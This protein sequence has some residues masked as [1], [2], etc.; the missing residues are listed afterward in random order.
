MVAAVALTAQTPSGESVLKLTA[1]TANVSGAGETVKFNLLHWSTDAERDQFRMRQ[2]RS[3]HPET[4]P[5]PHPST[6]GAD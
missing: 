1:T 2:S 5:V 3:T 4:D 6:S